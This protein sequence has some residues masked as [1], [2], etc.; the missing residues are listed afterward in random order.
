MHGHGIQSEVRAD[1]DRVQY[2]YMY[3]SNCHHHEYNYVDISKCV[4]MGLHIAISFTCTVL[5]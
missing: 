4:S 5:P 2:V 1:S 3:P